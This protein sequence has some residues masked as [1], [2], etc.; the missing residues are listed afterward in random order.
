MKYDMPEWLQKCLSCTHS[1]H[2]D[3]DADTIYCRCRNGACNYKPTK[4]GKSAKGET[5]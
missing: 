4:S 5:T 2:K 3:D 1:Y